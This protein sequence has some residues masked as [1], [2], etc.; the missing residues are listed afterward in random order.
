MLSE[1]FA[2]PK[3]MKYFER[4]S[5]I[6]RGSYNEKE[7]AEY[8]NKEFLNNLDVAITALKNTYEIEPYA[9]IEVECECDCCDRVMGVDINLE[10]II[11]EL[12]DMKERYSK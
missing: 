10:D 5:E 8:Q 7:I 11:Q 9:T 1:N 3:L 2:Y 6:P 4:I 12:I